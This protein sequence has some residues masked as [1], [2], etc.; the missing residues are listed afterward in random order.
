MKKSLTYT[1]LLS[2]LT[3][4]AMNAMGTSYSYH[5][6]TS[7]PPNCQGSSC[8]NN[9]D[10]TMPSD[11]PYRPMDESTTDD[12]KFAGLS[13]EAFLSMSTNVNQYVVID[14]SGKVGIGKAPA[15]D[16]RVDVKG[17][18]K[19]SS[20]SGSGTG[21]LCTGGTGSSKGAYTIERC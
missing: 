3:I 19:S 11:N 18:V 9:Y 12:S 2:F 10:G 5:V 6:T 20:L 1:F 8:T 7:S 21:F 14:K 16:V 13:L 4:F 15:S 17:S